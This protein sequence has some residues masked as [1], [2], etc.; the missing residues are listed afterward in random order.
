MIKDVADLFA[1]EGE[2]AKEIIEGLRNRSKDALDVAVAESP[3]GSARE[4]YRYAREHLFPLLLRLEDPGERSAAL[5]DV[6]EALSLPKRE[7]R[8]AFSKFEEEVREELE[9]ERGEHDLAPEPGSERYERAIELLEC[10]DVLRKVAEDMERLGH[11]GE[12][13]TKQLAFVCALSAKAGS[14]IQPSTHAQSSSGKNFLWDRILGF[15]PPEMVIRRSGLTAKALF[16]TR[17]SLQGAILYIQEVIGSED[18]D[19]SIRVLQSDGRLVYEATETMPDGSIGTVVYTKEGPCVVVQTTT[20]NHLHP[21][22]ETRVFPLY[23]DESEE[24][25]R[26]IIRSTLQEAAGGGVRAEEREEILTRWRDAVRL[27]EPV[28][29]IVPYA[30]RIELPSFQIRIRRD[31]RRLLDVVRVR[32]WLH[33][34]RRERDDEDRILASDEDFHATLELVEDSL[35]RAWQALT[36]AEEKVLEAVKGLP[37][38][39]RREGFKRKDLRVAGVSDQRAKEVF[40]S[41]AGTGYLDCDERK[42]PQGYTYTLAREAQKRS[43]GISLRPPSDD[44]E[45]PANEEETTGRGHDTRDRPASDARDGGRLTGYWTIPDE[46]R[47]VR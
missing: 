29:V 46:T 35:S 22:N 18:A 13:N 17:A 24:Q 30:E 9:E 16:R 27:L 19:F 32:A 33:Q 5:N 40:R 10:P 6:A 21:E 41:L 2:G 1:A 11:V 23:I 25:T 44:R 14:P 45:S 39:K 34:R 3:E 42:G 37:E 7:L 36:P 20:N 31:V 26:R 4:R 38:R 43:L 28:E 47:I 8:K 15:F 12:T